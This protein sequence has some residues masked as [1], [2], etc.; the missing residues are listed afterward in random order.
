MNETLFMNLVCT[1]IL[2]TLNYS[3]QIWDSK[4]RKAS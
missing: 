2:P 4:L 1:L 3:G